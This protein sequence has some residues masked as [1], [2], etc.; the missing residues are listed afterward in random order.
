[1]IFIPVP[2]QHSHSPYAIR[3]RFWSFRWPHALVALELLGPSYVSP[4]PHLSV[5]L[6]DGPS[7]SVKSGLLLRHLLH[8]CSIYNHLL[9][10]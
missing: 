10:L 4:V 2:F 3:P 6:G 5:H 1:M 7:V 8:F 9:R